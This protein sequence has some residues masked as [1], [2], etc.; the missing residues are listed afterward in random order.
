VEH[1]IKF[2]E[3]GT[4]KMMFTLLGCYSMTCFPDSLQG[5]DGILTSA[6]QK[7]PVLYDEIA[8]KFLREDHEDMDSVTVAKKII[9]A[10]SF[11]EK[12]DEEAML[13]REGAS[14]LYRYYQS[15]LD[16]GRM[17]PDDEDLQRL[18]G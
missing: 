4:D 11:L 12:A 2:P 18:P 17:T 9:K 13:S 6:A 16:A 7:F 3:V 1:N 8:V 5:K 14:I 15:E 10:I